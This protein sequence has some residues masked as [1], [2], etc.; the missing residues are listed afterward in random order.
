MLD[1][2]KCRFRVSI[3]L[4]MVEYVDDSCC[5]NTVL[6]GKKFTEPGAAAPVLPHRALF[7][8]C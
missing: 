8:F 7:V 5:R 1:A 4:H 3:F 2:G 6:A